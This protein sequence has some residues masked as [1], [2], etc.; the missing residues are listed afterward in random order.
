MTLQSSSWN[1][2]EPV[3][4]TIW[5]HFYPPAFVERSNVER[6][7]SLFVIYSCTNYY[8]ACLGKIDNREKC[9]TMSRQKRI[10]IEF[11]WVELYYIYNVLILKSWRFRSVSCLALADVRRCQSLASNHLIWEC[12]LRIICRRHNSRNY[13]KSTILSTTVRR[14]HL[15]LACTIVFP[16]N[17]TGCGYRKFAGIRWHK[18]RQKII[19]H[20]EHGWRESS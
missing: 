4:R 9:A 11:V 7:L 17:T 14:C 18:S 12:I 6:H 5:S 1:H 19:C 8:S 15:W 3:G 13:Q 16:Q 2:A 20:N 10:F